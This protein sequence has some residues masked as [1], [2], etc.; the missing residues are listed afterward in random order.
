MDKL[1]YVASTGAAHIER[2][3]AVHANNLANVSTTGFQADLAHA[4]SMQVFG[5]GMP[6]RV[7]AL[8]ENPATDFRPGTLIQTGRSLDVAV[9]GDG[10][11]AVGLPD[12]SEGYT[13]NGDLQVDALGQLRTG[14][15]TPVLGDAGPIALPPFDALDIGAD[16]SISIVPAGQG[17]ETLVQVGRIKL[18]EP[19]PADLT[20]GEDGL[21]R[22]ADG[23]VEA[24]SANVSLVS[25]N[26]ESSNVNPVHEMTEIISL[27]R[28]FEVEVRLMQ[29]AE[30]MDEASAQLVRVS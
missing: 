6:S 30:Q 27:A 24:A 23:G 19:D 26:L 12:G 14:K 22:R 7:Y 20:K 16:G 2:A 28:Q 3:Q 13:R 11:L 15:G 29:T 10:F 25:G 9:K 21:L 5:D 8:T 18:V 17:P 4:R 1:L